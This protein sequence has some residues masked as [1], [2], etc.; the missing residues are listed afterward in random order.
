MPSLR[1]QTANTLVGVIAGKGR[2]IHTGNRPQKPRRLPF[3]FHGSSRD[4]GLSAALDGAGVDAD[5]S[6]PIEVEG[7]AY[8]WQQRPSGENRNRIAPAIVG[9]TAFAIRRMPAVCAVRNASSW[10]VI[11]WH[12]S[13]VYSRIRMM[14]AA[15]RWYL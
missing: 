4:M 15:V 14:S 9:A 6:D 5:F 13:A 8:I 2:Q 7:D 1:A 10:A 11:G 12:R 3:F